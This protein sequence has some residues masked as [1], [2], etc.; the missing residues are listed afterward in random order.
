MM[1]NTYTRVLS[2]KQ[3][4]VLA[5]EAK[6]VQYIVNKV[7]VFHTS[8]VDA[9]TV[10]DNED[11]ALVFKALRVNRVT[12]IVTFSKTYWQSPEDAVLAQGV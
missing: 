2:T 9:I 3:V 5:K 6:R 4:N 12:W 8:S 7:R 10:L 11:N 1:K